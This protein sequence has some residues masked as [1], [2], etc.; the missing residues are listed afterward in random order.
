MVDISSL[1]DL[2]LRRTGQGR[3]MDWKGL[4]YT[5]EDRIGHGWTGY[6]FE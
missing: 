6:S 3:L 1:L 4:P 5:S 2:T